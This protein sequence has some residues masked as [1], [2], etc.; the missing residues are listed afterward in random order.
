MPISPFLSLFPREERSPITEYIT[1]VW[2][3]IGF[4]HRHLALIHLSLGYSRL[5]RKYTSFGVI[6]SPRAASYVRRF[7]FTEILRNQIFTIHSYRA[8][9]VQ[10]SFPFFST[11]TGHALCPADPLDRSTSVGKS[12]DMSIDHRYSESN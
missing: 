12:I 1:S 7:I 5:L 6:A 11:F 9:G 4:G 3:D 10:F 2:L 8:S